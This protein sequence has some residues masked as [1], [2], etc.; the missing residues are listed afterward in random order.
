MPFT[1]VSVDR[2]YKKTGSPAEKKD[3]HVRQ[4]AD[5]IFA[6]LFPASPRREHHS[7]KRKAPPARQ[8][9]LPQKDGE[10]RE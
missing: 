6:D 10:L 4:V 2:V 8:L 7:Q 3:R 1:K 5:E 9:Y